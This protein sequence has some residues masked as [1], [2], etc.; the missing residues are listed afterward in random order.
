[1]QSFKVFI[2]IVNNMKAPRQ[3]FVIMVNQ[4]TFACIISVSKIEITID[5]F[6]G[7][8]LTLPIFH[9]H[10]LI[11]QP[12]DN[13]GFGSVSETYVSFSLIWVNIS[14]WIFRLRKKKKKRKRK[15]SNTYN[16][17]SI[18]VQD[19]MELNTFISPPCLSNWV[20]VVWEIGVF[21]RPHLKEMVEKT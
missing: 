1:M 13:I 12:D 4:F 7:H 11:V 10:L 18:I 17:Q 14:A 9:L 16:P 3:V 5:S 15:K 6:F 2:R 21:W 19:I 20:G 8:I